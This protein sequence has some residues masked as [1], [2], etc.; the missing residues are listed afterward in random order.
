MTCHAN[1]HNL[2]WLSGV[3]AVVMRHNSC[4]YEY[5]QELDED[6]DKVRDRILD[7]LVKKDGFKW[8]KFERRDYLKPGEYY[9]ITGGNFVLDKV[10]GVLIS[11]IINSCLNETN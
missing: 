8:L 5:F 2:V 6:V 3:S 7:E 10:Y 11:E 1:V 4:S 9:I